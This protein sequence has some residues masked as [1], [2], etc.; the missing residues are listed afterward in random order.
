MRL[1]NFPAATRL[2]A[3]LRS[4]LVLQLLCLLGACTTRLTPVYDQRLC[5]ALQTTGTQTLILLAGAAG[6]TQAGA[7]EQRANQYNNLIGQ[8]DMLA[9]SAAARPVPPSSTEAALRRLQAARG[10]TA[11]P[12]GSPQP[13]AP[14]LP[15]SVHAIQKLAETLAKMRDTDRQQGLSALEVAAF[16]GQLLIYLDQAVSYENFLQP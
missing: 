2:P 5:D 6:G 14:E 7:F 15:P 4:L 12:A 13:A 9:I 16:K 3:W 1:P 11:Q 8:F 10:Q